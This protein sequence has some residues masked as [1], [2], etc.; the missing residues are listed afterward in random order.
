[1]RRSPAASLAILIGLVLLAAWAFNMLLGKRF[2]GG[3]IYAPGSS[4][5]ADPL[6]AKALHDSLN[7]V[8]GVR[9]ERNFRDLDKLKGAHDKTLLCLMVTPDAFADGEDV[10]GEAIL[11]FANEGGRVVI[12]MQG[13]KSDWDTVMDSAEERREENAERRREER[14]KRSKKKPASEQ[15]KQDE[16][17]KKESPKEKEE[18]PATD[19]DSEDKDDYI[20]PRKSLRTMLGVA[21]EQENFVMTPGGALELKTPM[22][23]GVEQDT[24]PEWHTRTSIKIDDVAREKWKALGLLGQDVVLAS[25]ATEAGGS[26]ILATDSYFLTNEA[27]YR[28]PS[29]RFLS[30]LLGPAQTVIF[31]ETH[32]GTLEKPG[33]MTLARRHRLHGL[34][35]GGMLLFALFVWRSSMSL[36][37]TRD[38]DAPSRTVA[39]RG[40]TAGLVSLLRRGI[41]SAQ[42][43]RRGLEVWEHGSRQRSPAMQ[44]RIDQARQ[45]LP[46]T[47]ATRVPG[48]AL[49]S[50][51]RLMCDMLNPRATT[52]SAAPSL[53]SS[54]SK[55]DNSSRSNS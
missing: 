29:T 1:M 31:E 14:K 15:K 5:R 13:Q 45:H 25:R 34:F 17:E 41:P 46:S 18:S 2:A 37:P 21:V 22:G 9:A 11:R 4:L 7:R 8:S 10:D 49:R 20:R 43:L 55:S 19:K 39:G 16:K 54:L 42:V 52:S 30:W 6:G 3:D 24:L 32:L 38:D 33:V 44:A 12:A 36:V 50:I 53:P 35:F 51:Y 23:V 26:I 47:E 40:A 27:L 48:G 28:E